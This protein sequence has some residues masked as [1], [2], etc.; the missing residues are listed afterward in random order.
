MGLKAITTLV[1]AASSY[2]LTTL[3]VVK[4]ELSISDAS[5][6]ASLKRYITSASAAAAQYCNRRFQ[7]E[8]V[9][10]EFWPD[11]DFYS[12][13]L[14]GGVRVIQLSRW[15]I[16]SAVVVLEN[17]LTLVDGTDYRVDAEN[18]QLIRLDANLY[19]RSWH[20]FPISAQY[21]AG[22]TDIPVEVEDAV[23][24]MVTKRFSAKGR[25]STLKA[26]DIPGVAS[27]QFWIATGEDAGNM[28][29]DISDVLDNYRVPVVA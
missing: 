20:A 8:T 18:G 11:R 25:D 12:S 4:D 15:P 22:F 10:D 19:P 16:T 3:A 27:R 14:P 13:P 24:R 6:D 9:K 29:P 5:R 26:E 17:G 1:S 21:S 23:V 2:D 7:V 28:T